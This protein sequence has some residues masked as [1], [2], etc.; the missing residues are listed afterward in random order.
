MVRGGVG[1]LPLGGRADGV[2]CVG[3]TIQAFQTQ[4]R[5][6]LRLAGD[7]NALWFFLIAI[8]SAASIAMQ[9]YLFANASSQLTFRLRSLSFRAILRQDSACFFFCCGAGVLC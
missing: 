7:R 8:L 1:S 3:G 2:F 5:H 9:N 6:A 4:D